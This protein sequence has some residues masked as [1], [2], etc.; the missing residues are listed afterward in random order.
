MSLVKDRNRWFSTLNDYSLDAPLIAISWQIVLAR[1]FSVDL[2]VFHHLILGVSVW[3]S[4]GADRFCEPNLPNGRGAR[5]HEV[6]KDHAGTFFLC[7][8]TSLLAIV[9]CSLAHL[10]LRCI[11]F[12]LCL[13]I[14]CLVNFALCRSEARLG[15]ASPCAKEIRTAGIL[16]LGCCFFPAYETTIGLDQVACHWAVLFSLF[17]VNCLAVSRWDWPEDEKRGRLSFF[18]QSPKMLGLSVWV[19]YSLAVLFGLVILARGVEANLWMH[20]LWA[21]VFVISLDFLPLEEQ[22]KR[23][24]IDLGYWILPLCLIGLGN[25]VGI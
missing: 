17:L 3:L 25:V 16:S 1:D 9:C 14:L 4:Y 11:L 12:G 7:W 21:C 5:R 2:S 24:A 18:Q 6:F 10:E 19:K 20:A 23:E 8:S 15:F 22:H 13:T